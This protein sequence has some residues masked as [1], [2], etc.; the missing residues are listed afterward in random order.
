[1]QCTWSSD[2]HVVWA[3]TFPTVQQRVSDCSKLSPSTRTTVPP[4]DGPDEGVSEKIDPIRRLYAKLSLNGNDQ[5]IPS[6]RLTRIFTPPSGKAG[7][8][9]LS[10]SVDKTD[11]LVVDVPNLHRAEDGDRS[12]KLAPRTM[13]VVDSLAMPWDGWSSR[14]R[15]VR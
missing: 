14:M 2:I 4:V 7:A 9:H 6:F 1:M 10:L 15:G 11:P 12:T 8:S 3:S 13:T 5:S